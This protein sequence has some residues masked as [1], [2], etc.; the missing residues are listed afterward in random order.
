LLFLISLCAAAT[1]VAAAR[2]QLKKHPYI[3]Y[4]AAVALAIFMAS[5][6]FAASPGWVRDYV[7]AP[8][9]RGAFAT[10]LFAVV[11]YTGALK[12]GSRLMK[13]LLPI[14]AELSIFA[15]ILIFTHNVFFGKTYFKNLF[16]P[17]TGLAAALWTAQTKIA[18]ILSLV[19]LCILLPLFVTSFPQVRKKMDSRSWKRLQRLAYGF[20]G[21]TYIHVM[22]LSIPYARQGKGGYSL[23]VAAYSAVF[24]VYAAMRVHK[25]LS[26]SHRALVSGVLPSLTAAAMLAIVCALTFKAPPAPSAVPAVTA[27]AEAPPLAQFEPSAEPV[28]E[29]SAVTPTSEPTIEPTETPPE[30]SA[31]PAAIILTPEPTRTP[32]AA[33][34]PDAALETAPAPTPAPTPEPTAAPE[35]APTPTPTPTPE[36]LKTK[37]VDGTFTGTGEGYSGKIT[38]SVT[39]SGDVIT[40]ISQ[41]SNADDAVFFEF[42]WDEVSGA[43]LSSQSASVSAVSGA[44]FSSEG[45]KSAVAD[46]L[47][48]ALNR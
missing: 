25:A 21:L 3:F 47:K 39:I 45:I 19:M 42:A 26:K 22:V 9:Q 12:N 8:F 7:I 46:A 44:T 38:V 33:A 43:I 28:A 13:I 31:E 5:G 11:M 14:R 20:Y 23:T 41:V 15:S 24:L 6:D 17:P 16:V 37:Y 2:G 18:A 36:P 48:K 10:A 32:A 40:A 29:P 4:G 34:S 1:F 35:P 30:P 27:I